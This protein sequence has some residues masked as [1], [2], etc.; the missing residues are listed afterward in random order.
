MILLEKQSYFATI[1]NSY[2]DENPNLKEI[3]YKGSRLYLGV[4]IEINN[5]RCFV[6]LRS[7]IKADSKYRKAGYLLP[8]SA[9]KNAGL[10]FRKLLII[11][12]LNHVTIQNKVGIP[13]VQKNKIYDEFD[14]ISDR[15]N[16]YVQTYVKEVRRN[17]ASE[18]YLYKFS[19]LKNYHKELNI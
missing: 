10:D 1:N 17:R 14:K 16:N 18:N 7:E 12:D 5:C 2:F 6:P 3:L 15:L 19:T 13:A 11:S 9:R 4:V 8:S